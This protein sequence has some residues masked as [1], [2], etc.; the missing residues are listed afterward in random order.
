LLADSLLE[1]AGGL[2]SGECLTPTN[3]R[4]S[5]A[6]LEF[7][8]RCVMDRRR[9]GSSHSGQTELSERAVKKRINPRNAF[10]FV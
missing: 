4:S 2:K 8:R 10:R 6:V 5:P 9:D 7:E 3:S 1:F